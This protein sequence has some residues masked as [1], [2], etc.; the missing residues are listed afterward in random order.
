M[1]GPYPGMEVAQV[2]PEAIVLPHTGELIDLADKPTVAVAL[3]NVRQLEVELRALKQELTRALV[4]E[5]SRVGSKTLHLEPWLD[6]EI[7]GGT[8][9]EWDHDELHKL[10]DAGLPEDRFDALVRATVTW[11]VSTQEANRIAKANPE[12]ARIIGNA[13]SEREAPFR[14]SVKRK[15]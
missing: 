4:E 13:R 12:Y 14:A 8:E 15:G 5:S 7:S 10:R 1:S 11:R 2:A 6:V 3:D 9:V